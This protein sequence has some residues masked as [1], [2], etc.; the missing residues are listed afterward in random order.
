[1]FSLFCRL[2]VGDERFAVTDAAAAAA[3]AAAR[4]GHDAD[5]EDEF[6]WDDDAD[7]FF[8]KYR[9]ERLAALTQQQQQTERC[10]VSASSLNIL[11]L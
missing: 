1:M 3:P 10:E 5:A 11:I 9:A 8:E 6:D 4:S 2:A 7:P